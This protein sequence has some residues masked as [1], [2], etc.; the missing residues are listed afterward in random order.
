MK[1]NNKYTSR[2]IIIILLIEFLNG[3][4]KEPDGN[5]FDFAF[6]N[7]PNACLNNE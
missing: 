6:V 3:H 5:T 7:D 4:Q 1:Y 2:Q